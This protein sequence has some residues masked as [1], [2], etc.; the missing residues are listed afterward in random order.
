[1]SALRGA[2]AVATDIRYGTPLSSKVDVRHGDYGAL[3]DAGV[4]L[5][6]GRQREKGRRTDR[7][8]PQGRLRLLE[9]NAAIYRDV[10]PQSL[11]HSTAL[12]SVLG[13]QSAYS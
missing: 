1:M 8:D 13:R 9:K 6:T 5:I 10:V 2:E 7:S 11:Q 4:V 3:A 12:A